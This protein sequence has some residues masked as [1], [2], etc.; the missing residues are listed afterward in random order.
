MTHRNLWQLWPS[1]VSDDLIEK[2]ILLADDLPVNQATV[3]SEDDFNPDIRTS[4]VR[5]IH[6]KWVKEIL[7]D[8]VVQ[9]NIN[10]FSVDVVNHAEVQFTEY[11]GTQAGHYDW[12]H[13]VHWD[14][15][16]NS[17]RKLSITVQLSSSEE[18]EG[19]DFEFSECPSPEDCRQKGSVLI[20]PSYLKHRV[21]PVTSGI[22]R[23]LVAWFHGPRWR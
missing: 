9:A 21:T 20:F 16:A 1:N 19:G 10:A 7:W 15:S 6:E 13:D 22:R 5:W 8:Y 4:S 11:H 12:H 17:D 3:F 14:S 18:Y 23:S 2:I